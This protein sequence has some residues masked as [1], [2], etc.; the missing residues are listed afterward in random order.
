MTPRPGPALGPAVRSAATMAD[1]AVI[2]AGG[3]RDRRRAAAPSAGLYGRGARGARAG[4]RPRRHG[5]A[6]ADTRS[7]SARIGFTPGR[8]IR[9]SNSD[10]GGASRC[11]GRRRAATSSS[12]AA[13]R[14][15]PNGRRIGRGFDLADRAFTLPPGPKPIGRWRRRC[16]C[17]AAGGSRSPPRMRWSADGRSAR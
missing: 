17:S 11:A 6:A 1:V 14:R 13:W 7:T 15:R 4:R 10:E 5:V 8:S 12:A 9:S 2:G 16:R 3:R